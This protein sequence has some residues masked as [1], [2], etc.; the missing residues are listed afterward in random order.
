MRF[1]LS[2]RAA[3]LEWLRF[4]GRF[5]LPP[6]PAHLKGEE[7]DPR[8][9]VTRVFSPADLSARALASKPMAAPISNPRCGSFHH[10]GDR[11]FLVL[12]S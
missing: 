10:F 4:A 8:F 11:Q 1:E 6:N 7:E 2:G 5:F 9:R 12:I 3:R